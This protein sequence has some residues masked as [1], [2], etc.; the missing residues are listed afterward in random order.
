[1]ESGPDR[2]SRKAGGRRVACLLGVSIAIGAT[3]PACSQGE[4]VGRI[5]GTLDVPDC[6]TGAFDLSPDFLAAVPYREAM[7]LR[8]QSGSDFQNFSDGLTILISDRTKIRPDPSKGFAGRYG[9]PLRVDLPPEVTPPGTPVE[10]DADPALVSMAL[11]LQRSCR[12]KTVTLH[13]VDEVTIPSDGTCT[14]EAMPGADPNQGCAGDKAGPAGTGS[15][16]SFI[17]FT[18]ISN[19]KLDEETA[20]E[21]LNAGCFD[22]YLADPREEQPGGQGPPP[23]C[24]GHIRG[25]FSFFFERG[26]PSQPFP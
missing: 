24:R 17:T 19:G 25:S 12:T 23:R 21:R 15:G 2:P 16:K 14:A 1:M 13:A 5:T 26:R 11:Y 22:I 4:G 20:A 8:V 3:S 6:W 10:P 18:S 7:T 9:Q